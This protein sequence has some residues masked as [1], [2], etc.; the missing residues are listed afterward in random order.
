MA[1]TPAGALDGL[2]LTGR[3]VLLDVGYS[4]WP[5]ALAAGWGGP[6]VGGAVMLLHQ[7]ARQVELM[8]GRTAPLA[9]M[10]AALPPAL[11]A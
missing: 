3:G 7:A 11:L 2:G 10:R 6:V 1:T 5:T 9:A 8:T 4:P